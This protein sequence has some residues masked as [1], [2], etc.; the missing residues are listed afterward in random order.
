MVKEKRV[1]VKVK[2]VIGEIH[3]EEEE[4]KK[5]NKRTKSK[6]KR[7]RKKKVCRE[8]KMI[9]NKS[10]TKIKTQA[11]EYKGRTD[12]NYPIGPNEAFR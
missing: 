3:R 5:K 2:I 8:E 1:K 11:E 12:N 9:L 7:R 10:R 6:N 4:E